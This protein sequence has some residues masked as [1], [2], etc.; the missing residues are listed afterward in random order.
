MRENKQNPVRRH[1]PSLC[2][3][4]QKFLSVALPAGYGFLFPRIGLQRFACCG[5]RVKAHVAES[6]RLVRGGC[7]ARIAGDFSCL[8][9][10]V[11][12]LHSNFLMKALER[13]EHVVEAAFVVIAQG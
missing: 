3:S 10:G 2:P 1:P 7:C 6:H 5:H 12:D 9:L 8:T 13:I 4:S 11:Y